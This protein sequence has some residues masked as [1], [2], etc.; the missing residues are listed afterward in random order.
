MPSWELVFHESAVDLLTNSR[1]KDKQ[2]LAKALEMLAHNPQV[3]PDYEERD[4]TGRPLFVIRAGPWI[5]TYWLD[6]Y[7][8]EVRIVKLEKLRAV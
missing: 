5:I 7:V 6:H 4:S 1:R 3:Q 8:K 2:I